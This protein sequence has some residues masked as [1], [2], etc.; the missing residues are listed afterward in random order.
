MNLGRFSADAFAVATTT[1]GVAT[2]DVVVLSEEGSSFGTTSTFLLGII[3]VACFDE[4]GTVTGPEV[5]LNEEGA[6]ATG[7]RPEVGFEEE[8]TTETGPEVTT[9]LVFSVTSSFSSGSSKCFLSSI[10][11]PFGLWIFK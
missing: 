8:G 4:G 1:I 10:T 6:T 9:A 2:F 11:V 3:S 7:T 5:G